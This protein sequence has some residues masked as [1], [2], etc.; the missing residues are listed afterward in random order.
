MVLAELDLRTEI[1]STLSD[2]MD[3]PRIMDPKLWPTARSIATD[4]DFTETDTAEAL[5]ILLD[6]EFIKESDGHFSITGQG[7]HHL[8]GA[9]RG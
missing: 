6:L 4:L 8:M 3:R 2:Q 1:I 9:P 5:E 7:E